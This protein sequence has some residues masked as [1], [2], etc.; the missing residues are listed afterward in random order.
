MYYMHR[1]GGF[2]N[3]PLQA[4][5]TYTKH[6]PTR[7]DPFFWTI[8]ANFMASKT[9]PDGNSEK[10]LC[11]TMAYRMCAKAAEAVVLETDQ[12]RKTSLSTLQGP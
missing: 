7:R 8:F 12:V 6:F 1:P 3:I 5:M 4:G 9:L 2:P 11:G 10:Q